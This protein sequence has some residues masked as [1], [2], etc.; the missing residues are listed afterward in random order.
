MQP[1]IVIAQRRRLA[2]KAALRA[3]RA[4]MR[5]REG[6]QGQAMVFALIV[7]LIVAL[8]PTFVLTNL[9]RRMPLFNESV[10]FNAALAAAQAGVQSYRNLLDAY[11]S[12]YQYN[13]SSTIPPSAGGANLAFTS[14]VSVGTANPP[15]SFTYTPDTSQ[16]TQ[17]AGGSLAGD[18]LLTVIGR[19]G[20][21]NGTTY[22]RIEAA[23]S[24]SGVLTDLYYSNYE[25]PGVAD[26]DQWDQNVY[27]LGGHTECSPTGSCASN[28]YD[29]ITATVPSGPYAGEAMATALC[30]V[31]A[32]QQNQYVDWY[33]QNVSSLFPPS[34]AY[35]NQGV[36]YNTTTNP[37]YGPW[38]G[39]FPDPL[40]PSQYQF[41]SGDASNNACPVNYWI[42][43][44][45]FNGPVYSQD[46]LTTC[47]SPNFTGNPGLQ[48]AA[49]SNFHLPAGWPG[50]HQFTG[51]SEPYGYVDDPFSV[52]G[53]GGDAPTFPNDA[54]SP[55][56]SVSQTLPPVATELKTEI[57]AG[58]IAGC[59]YSGPTAIRFY[60]NPATQQEQ[61]VVWS[62]LTKVTYASSALGV[63]CGAWP[64][65][66]PTTD[67][68]SPQ[69]T[70]AA[71]GTVQ[72]TQ[73]LLQVV[74]VTEPLV[75]YVQNAPQWISSLGGYSNQDPNAWQTLPNA[76]SNATIAG[77][78]DPFVNTSSGSTSTTTCTE[79]DAMLGGM[80]GNGATAGGQMTVVS[81]SSNIISR[82]LVYNCELSGSG[83]W[84]GYSTG[85]S[86][87]NSSL[88]VLGLVASADNWVAHPLSSGNEAPKCNDDYDM[89]A[90]GASLGGQT[91]P[92]PS[93]PPRTGGDPTTGA[94]AGEI[95][96]NDMTPTLCDLT[97]PIVDAATASLSGF[98]EI[99]N[100]REGDNSGGTLYLNGSMAVNN[101]GQFGVFTGGSSPS[102]QKGYLLNLSYDVRLRYLTPPSFV[103][104]TNSVWNIVNWTTCA[105]SASATPGSA[106]A[107]TCKP[108]PS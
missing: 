4:A 100:W 66:Q 24:L 107:K 95:D 108:L 28:A 62:P 42:S 36:A 13:S 17:S 1:I 38:Y 63:S 20:I 9:D 12:Y 96:F 84:P 47:G 58:Q 97:N 51:Y 6:E 61:M 31:D 64:A 35:P 53:G 56:F 33:S 52:C 76:E 19:A 77:C 23:F 43:G 21:R 67:P 39:T 101:A 14:W 45:T 41:G 15:E 87:C 91:P 44:D 3:R 65:T 90:P 27:T 92:S 32:W 25:Q 46:E 68:G 60:W 16:L 55:H 105:N 10:N 50:A 29:E 83:D 93:Y 75:I 37:Y 81:E 78:I 69:V 73:S 5:G 74:N 71:P 89:P 7:V 86:G 99:R 79:G 54:Q 26:Q 82:S 98:L 18:V 80:T 30:Q 48:T 22:R 11:P 106:A 85:I 88:D 34:N 49:A 102:L 59:I 72:T 40:A 2:V 8:V 57:E 103:Q 70:G 104:A 94:L